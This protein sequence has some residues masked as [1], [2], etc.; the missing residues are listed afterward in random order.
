MARPVSANV[1]P[2][3]QPPRRMRRRQT[4]R[5]HYSWPGR[6][7]RAAWP[8]WGAS[9]AAAAVAGPALLAAA[10]AAPVAAQPV[11]LSREARSPSAASLPDSAW[12]LARVRALAG[13]EFAGRGNG[14][15]EALAAAETIAVWFAAAG[16]EPAGELGWF[17]DF[18]LSGAA[19]GA[20]AGLPARNVLGRLP[21][22]GA[23]AGSWLVAGAHYD[24]LGRVAPDSAAAGPAFC[25]GA[26]D[27]ASGVAA[28]LA[29][30]RR[31]AGDG[32]AGPARSVL[33][34]AFA[35]E[36]DGLQGSAWLA[37]HLPLSAD[38]LVAMLNLD[39]VGRL[40]DSRVYVG[41]AGTAAA[42][43]ALLAALGGAHG[44]TL[45]LGR[46]GWD[47]SDHVSFQALGVPVL[48][49]MTGPHADYH[50]P[51]DDWPRVAAGGLARVAGFAADLLAALRARPGGLPYVAVAEPPP[52]R[53]ARAPAG[54][55]A[56]STP[57]AGGGR[58]R[59]AWFGVVPEFVDGV[60]GVK[61]AGVMPG[62][63]AAAAGLA[64]D[65]VLQ[66]FAGRRVRDLAAYTEAL[67]AH[68]PGDTVAVEVR[69]GGE[70]LRLRVVLAAR[71]DRR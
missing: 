44:L 47:A 29:V 23:L 8:G 54:E 67:R 14:S 46:G 10:G 63:P 3:L 11:A 13:P 20:P 34:A 35:G 64:R 40:R 52:S 4:A 65:D 43:P 39:T 24:H 6:L 15:A 9:L 5:P 17:Q 56:I 42:F 26:D 19:P 70:T 7:P 59:R 41:G 28:L 69:R 36:E 31:L 62:S 57:S 37:R 49:L 33:F 16:L 12:L 1:F 53:A 21:G 51:R 66:V 48:F 45:E 22:R 60:E 2:S 50:T 58:E 18:A 55:P 38:S 32:G 71:A 27:N 25:P 68:D 30:A 61:L